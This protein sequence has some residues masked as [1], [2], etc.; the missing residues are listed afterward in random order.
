MKEKK[1]SKCLIFFPE[2]SETRN[3][4]AIE[5]KCREGNKCIPGAAVCDG[6]HDCKDH[7][8]ELDCPQG[9]IKE[10]VLFR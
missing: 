7:S 4:T 3:C 8:D 2:F 5:F 6:R 10:S 9:K 1:T